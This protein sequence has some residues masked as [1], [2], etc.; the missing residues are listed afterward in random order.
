MVAVG[1]GWSQLR[2]Q[3]NSVSLFQNILSAL[4]SVKYDRYLKAQVETDQNDLKMVSLD[5]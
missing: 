2:R 1:E 4:L 5:T 3:L